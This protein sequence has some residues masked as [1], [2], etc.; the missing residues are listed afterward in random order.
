MRNLD[1]SISRG[2]RQ[3]G[4]YRLSSSQSRI[5][6]DSDAKNNGLC[7]PVRGLWEGIQPTLCLPCFSLG[8]SLPEVWD[9]MAMKEREM[10]GV[11]KCSL[12]DQ[13]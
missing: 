1:C 3:T 9:I 8:V 12:G 13:G 4:F 2:T 5:T 11:A 10:L 6:S 7:G